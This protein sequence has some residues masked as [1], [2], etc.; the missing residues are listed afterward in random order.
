MLRYDSISEDDRE[1]LIASEQTPA[2]DEIN[3]GG[4][5]DGGSSNQQFLP[6]T[7]PVAND[8]HNE[9]HNVELQSH[10]EITDAPRDKWNYTYLV[11]Y[12][13]G[14]GTMTPWNFFVTA[15]DVSTCKCT[16]ICMYIKE[17]ITHVCILRC[18]F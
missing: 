16:H 1:N 5:L 7:L 10:I 15:E 11:F 9:Y 6:A 17:L 14:M 18:S 3:A 12:L 4:F 13:L 8:P 2:I